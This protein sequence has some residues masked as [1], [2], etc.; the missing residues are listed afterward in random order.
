MP[1]NGCIMKQWRTH[2]EMAVN[3]KRDFINL[4]SAVRGWPSFRKIW[5]QAVQFQYHQFYT[6]RKNI[7]NHIFKC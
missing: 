6:F 4:P 1:F 2:I 7:M 5:Q 3:I